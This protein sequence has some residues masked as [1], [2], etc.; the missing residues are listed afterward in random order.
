MSTRFVYL[1]IG[2]TCGWLSA[3]YDW[4]F[5]GGIAFTVAIFG[6]IKIIDAIGHRIGATAWARRGLS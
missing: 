3:S 4:S 2:S 5:L 1:L 6:V